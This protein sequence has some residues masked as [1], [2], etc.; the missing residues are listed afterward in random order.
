[1]AVKWVAALMVDVTKECRLVC[2][3]E[4]WRVVTSRR[5]LFKSQKCTFAASYEICCSENHRCKLLL[6]NWHKRHKKRTER[7]TKTTLCPAHIWCD[8]DHVP[9]WVT[10]LSIEFWNVACYR[11]GDN[12]QK[13]VEVPQSLWAI[14]R[15]R[16]VDLI[17]MNLYIYLVRKWSVHASS[18]SHNASLSYLNTRRI[19]WNTIDKSKKN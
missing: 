5:C 13:L 19:L 14:D 8:K 3:N 6:T 11:A 17:R 12:L 2:W 7:P 1:M 10:Q 18:A 15:E 9:F 4:D 16:H